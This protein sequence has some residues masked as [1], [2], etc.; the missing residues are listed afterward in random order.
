[1]ELYLPMTVPQAAGLGLL[2]LLFLFIDLAMVLPAERAKAF[3][4][5]SIYLVMICSAGALVLFLI[6]AISGTPQL[7]DARTLPW[8]L[9]RAFRFFYLAALAPVFLAPMQIEKLKQEKREQ[10]QRGAQSQPASPRPVNAPAGL[11]FDGGELRG[12]TLYQRTCVHDFTLGGPAPSPSIPPSIQCFR[13]PGALVRGDLRIDKAAAPSKAESGSEVGRL[14]YFHVQNRWTPPLRNDPQLGLLDL[15]TEDASLWEVAGEVRF[16]GRVLSCYRLKAS[17]FPNSVLLVF[18]EDPSWA[19][20][21][22]YYYYRIESTLA[23]RGD[24]RS[25][26]QDNDL[27]E[28]MKILESYLAFLEPPRPRPTDLTAVHWEAGP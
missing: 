3:L 4:E 6:A 16:R 17:R 14:S 20:A 26:I 7:S 1:V 27:T 28:H 10:A 9:S 12:P 23:L 21:R 19:D 11:D 8:R 13:N 18:L 25:G 5:S 24:P 22:P 15:S 2:T